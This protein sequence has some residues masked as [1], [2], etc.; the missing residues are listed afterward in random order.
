METSFV[1]W[2]SP[3]NDHIPVLFYLVA[4]YPVASFDLKIDSS[5]SCY[6]VIEK[7]CK[8]REI[9]ICY[10]SDFPEVGSPE[11]GFSL[12]WTTRCL[13]R[14][15]F[16]ENRLLHLYWYPIR[17]FF[18]RHVFGENNFS[19]TLLVIWFLPGMVGKVYLSPIAIW[20]LSRMDKMF[21]LMC[22][23]WQQII[24]LF[25][26]YMDSLPYGLEDVWWDMSL[27]KIICR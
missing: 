25:Q 21:A 10:W 16:S 7:L 11:Y 6:K 9:A 26:D 4:F 12:L 23:S 5:C 2:F 17:R 15:E 20:F 8:N 13:L 22:S 14:F 24:A 27:V 19:H 18:I 1:H 3:L